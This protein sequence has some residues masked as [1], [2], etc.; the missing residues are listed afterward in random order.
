VTKISTRARIGVAIVLPIILL[1]TAYFIYIVNHGELAD[2]AKYSLLQGVEY[3]YRDT[4]GTQPIFLSKVNG[5]DSILGLET[6][7]PKYHHVW[8]LVNRLTSDGEI[9]MMPEVKN[10]K[11]TCIAIFGVIGKEQISGKVIKFL[12]KNCENQ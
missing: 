3:K 5:Q 1:F 2:K 4:A 11:G 12:E 7:D 9:A 8:I 6:N 10:I